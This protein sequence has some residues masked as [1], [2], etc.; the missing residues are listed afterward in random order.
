MEVSVGPGE[1]DYTTDVLPG[2]LFKIFELTI[3]K[4]IIRLLLPYPDRQKIENKKGETKKSKIVYWS[5]L[6]T[7][8]LLKIGKNL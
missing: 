5:S 1:E 3:F 8:T 7:D 6:L 4:S 2:G